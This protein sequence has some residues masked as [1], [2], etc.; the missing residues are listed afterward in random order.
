MTWRRRYNIPT[1]GTT[2]RS[3]SLM[4]KRA[5]PLH[6]RIAQAAAMS[7]ASPM[8]APWMAARTGTRRF[9]G[10]ECGLRTLHESVDLLA[11]PRRAAFAMGNIGQVHQ[12]FHVDA[13]GE[14]TARSADDQSPRRA[15]RIDLSQRLRQ[16]FPKREVHGV[17]LVGSIY[18]QPRDGAIK[19]QFQSGV[20]HARDL[21]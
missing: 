6:T 18:R 14:V 7:T 15:A 5:S 17:G 8:H 1:S 12:R 19:A 11:R 9:D 21:R 4:Q 20:G 16:F 2:A 3:T 13:G 10:V